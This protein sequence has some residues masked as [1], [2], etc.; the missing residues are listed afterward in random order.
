VD[1]SL[2]LGFYGARRGNVFCSPT[3]PLVTASDV[4]CNI[5]CDVCCNV[6]CS[7]T[8]PLGDWGGVR[9]WA[10]TVGQ[11]VQGLQVRNHRIDLAFQ[12]S[13]A[14]VVRDGHCVVIW[15]FAVRSGQDLA[16]KRVKL[17][18]LALD[19]IFVQL[20]AGLFWRVEDGHI[21]L[22]ALGGRR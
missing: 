8:A 15:F 11:A 12:I 20:D 2:W 9:A 6:C 5:C 14:I 19:L 1:F 7:P 21:D 10:G 4:C 16:L 22:Q 17:F 18:I 13:D 3:V